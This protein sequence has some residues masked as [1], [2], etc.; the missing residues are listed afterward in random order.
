[1]RFKK[2]I[3]MLVLAITVC[4]CSTTAF[5]STNGKLVVSGQTNKKA[6][7][8]TE[9]K[10]KSKNGKYYCYQGK[11]KLKNGIFTINNKKYYFDKNGVQRIGWRKIGN[12]CYFFN[13]KPAE[14]GYM[15]KGKTVDGVKIKKNGQATPKTTR[16]RLKLPM[17]LKVQKIADS[18]LDWRLSKTKLLRKTFDFVNTHFQSSGSPNLGYSTENWDIDYANSMINRNGGNCFGH[19]AIFGYL[20]NALGYSNVMVQNDTGHAWVQIGDKWYDPSFER[21]Y[22]VDSF[23]VSRALSG[24]G[25]RMNWAGQIVVSRNCDK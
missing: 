19:A 5:A 3:I 2:S 13:I 7:I 4:F 25:G 9:Y 17:M 6:S 18:V 16:A 11:K 21:W 23:A 20:A 1:M 8:N 14:K 22:H 12:K 10:W 15:I 24:T